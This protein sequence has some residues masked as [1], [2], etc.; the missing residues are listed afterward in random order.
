MASKRHIEHHDRA[1]SGAGLC[2]Q[3][4]LRTK[5]HVETCL[6]L[7]RHVCLKCCGARDDILS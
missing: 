3:V 1:Q 4:I 5:P 2:F 7:I 6:G